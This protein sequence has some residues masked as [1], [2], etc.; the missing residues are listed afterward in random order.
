MFPNEL[1]S[2]QVIWYTPKGDYGAIYYE[3][4]EIYDRIS[5]YAICVYGENSG[6]YLFGCNDKFE[7]IADY[8]CDSVDECKGIVSQRMGFSHSNDGLTENVIWRV[9][10]ADLLR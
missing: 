10:N 1:D 7:V 8:L 9:Q 2:A 5:Y 6:Y 4:G 3:T